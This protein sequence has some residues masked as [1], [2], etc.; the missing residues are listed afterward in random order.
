MSL[1]RFFERD[2]LFSDDA[3]ITLQS[4]FARLL[5]LSR[6]VFTF[7]AASPSRHAPPRLPGSFAA[8]AVIAAAVFRH[9]ARA[10][11]VS[12]RQQIM[13][14]A[15]RAEQPPRLR[16]SFASAEWPP[17]RRQMPMLPPAAMPRHTPLLRIA[18]R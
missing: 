8:A 4:I 18:A 6:V 2:F 1:F 3:L 16:Q 5:F 11:A 15:P 12:S 10:R 17:L 13:P 9:A 7:A 14:T